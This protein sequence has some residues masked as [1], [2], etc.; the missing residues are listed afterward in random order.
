M[1]NRRAEQESPRSNKAISAAVIT[2]VATIVAAVITTI[3]IARYG[4]TE[5]T[6]DPTAPPG[7]R[8][9]ARSPGD[10]WLYQVPYDGGS[11]ATLCGG[12][13]PAEESLEFTWVPHNENGAEPAVAFEGGPWETDANGRIESVDSGLPSL[14]PE[15]RHLLVHARTQG[16]EVWAGTSEKLIYDSSRGAITGT[17]PV[18][19]RGE[20]DEKV[21]PPQWP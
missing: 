12:N 18:I 6:A 8:P 11:G 13:F 1:P 14:G 16:G 3:G 9:A 2:A 15:V 20:E 7:D 19:D 5:D 17:E 4:S 21:C 10:P